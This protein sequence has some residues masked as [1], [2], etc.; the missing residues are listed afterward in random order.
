MTRS[1][2]RGGDDAGLLA[3]TLA[4]LLIVAATL[5]W[6]PV[7]IVGPPGYRG[8]SPI[9]VAGDLIHGRIHWTTACTLAAVAE[10]FVAALLAGAA[11]TGWRR[12]RR[13]R[14]RVDAAAR[15][16]ATRG[17]LAVLG[18]AGVTESARRLRP[19]LTKLRSIAGDDAGVLIGQTVA[20]GMPLRQSWEDMAVDIWGPRTGK[21]TARAIPAIVAAPGPVIVT[22]VKGDVVDATREVRA[23]RGRVW[24]FD[25]QQVLDEPPTWWWNPLAGVTT[26]TTA[27]RLAAHFASAEREPGIHRDA[28]FEPSAEE[29]VAN[30]LLAA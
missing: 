20:G 17:D 29:L 23:A 11:G 13:G 1:R 28:F 15:R 25:P 18:P 16:M 27:R 8:G 9:R 6:A 26:I 2:T 10:L 21:T 14:T 12:W 7:A 4:L 24:V 22:S 19:S 30:L 5:A 3:G